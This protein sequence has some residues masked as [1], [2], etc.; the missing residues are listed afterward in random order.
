MTRFYP[1]LELQTNYLIVLA[2]CGRNKLAYSV[3]RIR[4]IKEERSDAGSAAPHA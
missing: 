2:F 1:C 3:S 4:R